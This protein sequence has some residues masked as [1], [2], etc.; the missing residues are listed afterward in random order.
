MIPSFRELIERLRG[1]IH[2]LDNVVERALRGWPKA[3]H[4]S[5]NRNSSW[6]LWL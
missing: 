2:E 6:I 3:Q 5:P 4:P 1:E